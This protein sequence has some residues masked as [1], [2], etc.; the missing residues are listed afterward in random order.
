[1]NALR[2]GHAGAAGGTGTA[3]ARVP[4][5]PA[6]RSWFESLAEWVKRW[7]WRGQLGRWLGEQH[8]R[9]LR[10]LFHMFERGDF[11]AAL[12]HAI[13]ASK[14]SEGDSD[15]SLALMP[16]SARSSLALGT[17]RARARSV[18]L[19]EQLHGHLRDVL[20]S[21]VSMNRMIASS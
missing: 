19:G 9:Y 16:P 3:L 7:M 6:G 10:E 15:A 17:H 4:S 21:A 11:D 8:A 12:R 14:S 13:P 20:S 18:G 1:M 5:A 2:G